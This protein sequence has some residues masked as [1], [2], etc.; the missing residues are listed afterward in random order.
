M[1]GHIMDW[2]QLSDGYVL[3]MIKFRVKIPDGKGIFMV[4][5]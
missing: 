3:F 2:I 1:Y 5:S 4:R